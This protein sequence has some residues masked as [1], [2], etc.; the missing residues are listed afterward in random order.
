MT[1]TSEPTPPPGQPGP[2]DQLGALSPLDGRYRASVL[3]LA[4]LFSEAGLVRHRL[5]VELAW[6]QVLVEHLPEAATLAPKTA[7]PLLDQQELTSDATL[8][9]VKELEAELQHD[10]KS[11]EIAVRELL[12]AKG[13]GAL[14]PFVHFGCTSEDITNLAL[15]SMLAQ[16]RDTV[17]GPALRAVV[18]QLCSLAEEF[19]DIPMLSR[20][21]GQPA[22]PTT[23]GKEIAIFAHRLAAQYS[24]LAAWQPSGKFNGATG[25]YNAVTAACPGVDWPRLGRDLVEGRLGLCFNPY[26]TQI[27]SGDATAQ[28][29]HILMRCGTVCLDLARDVWGYVALDLLRLRVVQT[30][31]GSST[32][33]HK[34]NPIHFENAEGNLGLAEAMLGRLAAALPV[35]RWQRDLSGS[36]TMRNLG[37]GLGYSLQ[38]L[39]SLSTGL[40]RITA[41]QDGLRAD[42]E[43]RWEVLG[44]ALQTSLRRAGAADAYDR[45]K[46]ISRGGV[47]DEVTYRELVNA[48]NELPDEARADL[49]ALTPETY[50]GQAPQLAREAVR[51]A[52]ELCG[53]G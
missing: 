4:R 24:Q 47:M 16:A 14:A 26:T 36:T 51:Q 29:C 23:L 33:P 49:L 35:S 25:N 37:V 21:H 15:G 52:R 13:L 11:C 6:L 17:L 48:C 1:Q 50:I 46:Q 31:V 44:E 20:T 3:P 7:G 45:I 22:S 42:L 38:A 5:Q 28:L 43:D 27:E 34:V 10:V 32:M 18:A 39:R 53:E 41:N 2:S 40:D 8:H 19:A 12:E 30:E 9:R